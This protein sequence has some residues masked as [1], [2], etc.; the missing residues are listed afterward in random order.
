MESLLEPFFLS[1]C[2]GF[3][4]DIWLLVL[5]KVKQAN[6]CVAIREHALIPRCH[7]GVIVACIAI[8]AQSKETFVVVGHHL[9]SLR[10]LYLES[11]SQ[12]GN[13]ELVGRFGIA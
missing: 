9:S 5:L 6:E 13:H 1:I 3:A 10:R 2:P 12:T 11:E 4:I 8:D 7:S